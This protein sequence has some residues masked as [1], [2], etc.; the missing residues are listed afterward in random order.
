[1]RPH[2]VESFVIPAVK[3]ESLPSEIP[4]FKPGVAFIGKLLTNCPGIIA[5]P[6]ALRVQD[7]LPFSDPNPYETNCLDEIQLSW[8]SPHHLR[9]F[10]V[11]HKD[12]DEIWVDEF[13][14]KYSSLNLKGNNF[15]SPGVVRSGTASRRVVGYGLQESAV[16]R[17]VLRASRLLRTNDIST[18]YI[19]GLAEPKTLPWPLTDSATGYIETTS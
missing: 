6:M 18:E 5:D 10:E 2:P 16:M 14:H 9:S 11:K 17:R 4:G 3:D 15:S 1:M 8:P 12:L 7:T 13:G 19:L